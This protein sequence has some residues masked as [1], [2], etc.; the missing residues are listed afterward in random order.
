MKTKLFKNRDFSY[1]F[2]NITL[3]DILKKTNNKEPKNQPPKSAFSFNTLEDNFLERMLELKPIV[4]NRYVWHVGGEVYSYPAIEFDRISIVTEGLLCKKSLFNAVFANNGLTSI[5]SFFPFVDDWLDFHMFRDSFREDMT[6]YYDILE[7]DFWRIDTQAFNAKWYI[8]PNLKNDANKST[9]GESQINYICTITDIPP[10]AIR[11]Y[12][13]NEDAYIKHLPKL[14]MTNSSL[15]PLTLL[16][17]Y[18]K[19]FEWVR[20]RRPAA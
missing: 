2:D 8:D 17:L 14:M 19:Q 9:K 10:H 15:F 4:P 5:G 11:L 7:R 1:Q 12:T 18:D 3:S 20:R 13:F 16:K 6:P